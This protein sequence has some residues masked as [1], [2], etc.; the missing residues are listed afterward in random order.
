[1]RWYDPYYDLE[2]SYFK[3]FYYA[4]N[5]GYEMFF[6]E[7]VAIMLVFHAGLLFVMRNEKSMLAYNIIYNMVASAYMG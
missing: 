5:K 1:M 4:W 6:L 2:K 7:M 3:N